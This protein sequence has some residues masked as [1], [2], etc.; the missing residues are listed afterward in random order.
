MERLHFH[1]VQRKINTEK[2]DLI[3]SLPRSDAGQLVGGNFLYTPFSLKGVLLGCST[4]ATQTE[5][6]PTRNSW[7][8][9]AAKPGR[10]K[11]RSSPCN[12]NQHWQRWR[13]DNVLI[14]Q[15]GL[16]V[17]RMGLEW[18]R[19]EPTP[20]RFCRKAM[21]RYRE[22]IL[23]LQKRN[24]KVLVTLHHFSN[25]TWF[26]SQGG[27]LR[28]DSPQIFLRYVTYVVE[29]IGDIVSDYVTLNEPNTYVTLSYFLA[30]W[31]PA[32]HNPAISI[33]VMRNLVYCHLASYRRIHRI[34]EER[35]FSGRTMVG[36]AEHMRVFSAARPKDRPLASAMD[37]LF[38]G[39]TNA[40]YTG[41]LTAPLG[42]E[43]PFGDGRFYDYIGINY[44]TRLWVSGKYIG[45]KPDSE[46]TD[47]GWEV[48]PEGLS[49]LM[50]RR[51]RHLCAPIWITEN[52]IA[53][54]NDKQRCRFI[55]EHLRQ[56][57]ISGLPV[58]RYYY[59]TL[60][61]NFEWAEGETAAF[62][63]IG[64]DFK[65]Q[66]RSIRPSAHFYHEIIQNDGITQSM[67]DRYLK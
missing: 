59:W 64:C 47:L 27:F 29:S 44:Y 43:A 63:L 54:R 28:K 26:E 17:Y 56:I 30:Q 45:S 39:L 23:D 10:M 53:A 13:E 7:Y 33:R 25:P 67:I 52:G 24:V 62:G 21:N 9:W 14:Q 38:Q 2:F 50:R 42:V 35:G 36:F 31:P 22:E 55:Y 51:Y 20:G 60:M 16:Q 37:Y 4:S 34:R 15:L 11:D 61:D 19:I 40:M 46:Q 18:S 58:E 48:Y 49:L 8:D 65:T 6:S 32:K 57:A 66:K 5:G 3:L 1:A 12:A 41:R